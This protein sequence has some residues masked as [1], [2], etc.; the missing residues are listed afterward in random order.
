MADQNLRR[1]AAMMLDLK[2]YPIMKNSGAEWL[3][4]VPKHWDVLPN[5]VLLDEIRE[6]DCPGEEMLS[7]TI[8]KG[9]ILQAALL[10]DSSKKDSSNLDRS[11]YKLV[12]PG[13]IVYNKMR[14]W[15]GA[16]GASD[17]RGIVSPAYVIQRPRKRAL[18]RYFHRLFR[19]PSFTKEAERWSYGIT[20]D[21]WS[22]RPEHFKLIYS[23]LPPLPEQAA[24][25]RYLDYVDRRVQRLTRAKRRLIALLTEQ[26]Q[27]IIHRAVTHGLDPDVHL[28]YSGVEWLGRVPAHWRITALRHRYLQCLGKMLDSKR[29]IGDY[30]LPY[31]RNTDVQWDLINIEDLPAMDIFPDEYERYTVQRGDLLVCEGGEVGRCALWTGELT[32]CGFQKALHRL[33]PRNVEQDAP[34]FRYYILRAAANRGAFDDGR[35]STIAHLTGDKLKAHRFPFPPV[36]EQQS[37]VHFLDGTLGKID[38]KILLAGRQIEFIT[39][40]KDRLNTDVVTGKLDIR[41]ATAKLLEIGPLDTNTEAGDEQGAVSEYTEKVAVI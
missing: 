12:Q 40:Y 34:R 15:Q 3:K 37:I 1:D 18:P 21:M 32:L 11:N 29:I 25:V 14:A 41:E 8:R 24:I 26:K 20:S 31:L 38:R 36:E 35:L 19:T 23:C 28:K 7:V 17:Y 33:R 5:R 16:I 30:S 9:V 39:E 22:L 10:E 4:E 13:D 6:R 27:A 2:P